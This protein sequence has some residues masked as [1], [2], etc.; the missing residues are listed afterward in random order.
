MI[1]ILLI[2]AGIY[3]LF[4]GKIN[5]SKNRVLVKPISIYVGIIFIVLALLINYV[6]DL[7]VLGLLVITLVISYFLSKNISSR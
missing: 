6:S 2:I 1:Q 4:K 7:F 3:G 5:F